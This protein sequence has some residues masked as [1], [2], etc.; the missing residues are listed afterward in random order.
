MSKKTINIIVIVLCYFIS[1]FLFELLIG[2]GNFMKIAEDCDKKGFNTP[3]PYMT[4]YIIAGINHFV[5]VSFIAIIFI[6]VKNINSAY[7][8]II[9]SFPII[10]FVFYLPMSFLSTLFA[11]AF[12]LYGF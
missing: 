5:V 6:F 2:D 10:T 8:K 3:F 11:K 4:S 9:Y 7:K 12:H 1:L